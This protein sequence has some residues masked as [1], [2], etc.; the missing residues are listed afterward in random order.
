MKYAGPLFALAFTLSS[1]SFSSSA[2]A[3]TGADFG[4]RSPRTCA[5]VKSQPTVQQMAALV[6]CSQEK[7]FNG[8]V[9]ILDQVKVQA[10]SARAY[11]PRSDG[12]HENIDV[13]ANI[14]PIRGSFINYVCGPITGSS[15]KDAGKNCSKFTEP[16][17]E[18]ECWRST[19]G[20]WQCE[21][22]QVSGGENSYGQPP[23]KF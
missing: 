22:G 16:R 18:G 15:S 5:P 3:A 12:G 9:M 19:F 2:S 17:A 21:M 13:R 23:P 4:T 20:E 14:I 11:E 7:F 6:Q 8:D 10:G 1:L